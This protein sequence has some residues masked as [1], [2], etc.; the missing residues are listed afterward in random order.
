MEENDH[1]FILEIYNILTQNIIISYSGPFDNGV[2]TTI[3]ANI[4]YATGADPQLSKKV[5]SVFIELAQNIS[6]YSAERIKAQDG[7]SSGVGILIIKDFSDHYLMYTGNVTRPADIQPVIEKC[8]RINSLDREG[9]REFRRHKR[10]QPQSR[11]GG[12]NIGLIQV[13][14]I[15]DKPIDFTLDKIDDEFSFFTIS[16]RID[17]N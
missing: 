16:I 1:Q 13:A 10:S 7:H 5:F 12:G 15:T 4:Q 3:G 6:Y 8:E 17:K 11:F 14:L 9:L 2:L